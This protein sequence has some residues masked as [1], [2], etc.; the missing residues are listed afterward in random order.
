MDVL[1]QRFTLG[2]PRFPTAFDDPFSG[3]LAS[4][5]RSLIVNSW[6]A[7]DKLSFAFSFSFSCPFSLSS[8]CGM[9]GTDRGHVR[10]TIAVCDGKNVMIDSITITEIMCCACE[11]F[12]CLS[13]QTTKLCAQRHG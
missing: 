9:K 2:P 12:L 6:R 13:V 11:E 5:R 8:A 7:L 3:F 4:R 10:D 1:A